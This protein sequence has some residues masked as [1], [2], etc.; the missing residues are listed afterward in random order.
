[1]SAAGRAVGNRGLEISM[2]S[3]NLKLPL[4]SITFDLLP[5]LLPLGSILRIVQLYADNSQIYLPIKI[6]TALL[7]LLSCLDE[8]KLWLITF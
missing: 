4:G 3:V 5:L 8:V 1:M 2:G 6:M 7:T